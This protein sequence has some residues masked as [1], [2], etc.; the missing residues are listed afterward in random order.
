LVEMDFGLEGKLIAVTGSTAG[1]GRAIALQLVKAGATVVVNGRS[2]ESCGKAKEWLLEQAG[3]DAGARIITAPANLASRKGV[4]ELVAA[5]KDLK[6]PLYGLVNNTG[7]FEVKSFEDITDEQWAEYHET[8]V[9]S[10]VRL[11]RA[12]LGEM[13]E[14]NSGRIIFISSESAIRPLPHMVAY[15][16]TKAAQMNLARGLAELT[17]GTNV[18]VNSVLPGPTMTEGVE[19]YM[20][21]FGK[22]KGYDS[23]E[24]AVKQYFKQ[25]ETTSLLQRFIEPEEIANIVL[26]LLSKLGSAINGAAQRA[27]GGIVHHV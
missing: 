20:D 26:F 11:A 17:K 1:I 8:N 15:A 4:E 24:E 14:R 3:K 21:D 16:T 23:R 19:K 13:I 9:L 25:H 22:E 10:G 27:D 18:T 2:Q 7:F 12:F 5:I 6:T